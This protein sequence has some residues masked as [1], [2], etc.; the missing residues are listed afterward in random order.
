MLARTFRFPVRPAL[1][2]ASAEGT[3][4]A[5]LRTNT[6]SDTNR[7]HTPASTKQPMATFEIEGSANRI[8]SH[9][10]IPN[11]MANPRD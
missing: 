11:R 9:P 8:A 10:I 6:L 1:N 4:T 5:Q 3:I 7:T 2:P